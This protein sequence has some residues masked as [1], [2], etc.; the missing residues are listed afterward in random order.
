M[1]GFQILETVKRRESPPEGAKSDP[2]GG[3]ARPSGVV[4]RPL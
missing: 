2:A 3:L 1:R 4:A